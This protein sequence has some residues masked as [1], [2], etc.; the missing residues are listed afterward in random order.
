MVCTNKTERRLYNNKPR[1]L[2]SGVDILDDNAFADHLRAGGYAHYE[3]A[4]L[5]EKIPPKRDDL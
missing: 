5:K 1:D 4:E 3:A 2:V